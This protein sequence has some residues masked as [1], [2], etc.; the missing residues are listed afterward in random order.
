MGLLDTYELS[1]KA[2][3]KYFSILL[4]Y[5]YMKKKLL[6]LCLLYI[7]LVLSAQVERGIKA[8]TTLSKPLETSLT[9]SVTTSL[10]SAKY[11]PALSKL[12]LKPTPFAAYPLLKPSIVLTQP[13]RK[14]WIEDYKQLIANFEIFKQESFAFLYYQSL[15]LESRQ[16][17]A[18]EKRQWLGK[19]LP[20]HDKILSFYLTTQQDNALK[21]ALD[22]LRY[23]IFVVDPSLIPALRA[24][25]KPYLPDFDP[26]A[27]F[28]YPVGPDPLP[29]PSIAL[30]GK[31]IVIIND[32]R[33][34]LDHFEHLY[35]I[36][37]LFPGATLHVHGDAL[38]FLFWMGYSN[39]HPDIVFTDIQLGESNGFYV[40]SELRKSGYTGGLIALT[41]Y[42]ET[43]QNARQFKSAGFDGLVSLDDRYYGEI[44]FFQRV[45]QAAQLYMQNQEK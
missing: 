29:D 36:G 32:D 22:Y 33:S 30:D 35:H 41:S 42:V 11:T 4:H 44:P 38:Q 7:P 37:V 9:R 6:G 14:Q 21:Y 16:V 45:T 25:A 34:L 27:F 17:T 39:I 8:V 24:I 28:L 23:S 2:L 19:I 43:E 40:A 12:I 3:V 10:N 13:Q 1:T 5:K 20:L 26:Q 15:P 18:E 31:H